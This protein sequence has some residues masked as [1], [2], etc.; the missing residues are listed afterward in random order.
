[1]GLNRAQRSG[2]MAGFCGLAGI[3]A[4]CAVASGFGVR[5]NLT[6]SLPMGLYIERAQGTLVE[7]CPPGSA[8]ELSAIRGYRGVGVCPDRHAPLLKPVVARQGDHVAIDAQGIRVNGA[9]LPNTQAYALDHRRRPLT[10]YPAGDYTVAPNTLWV[11][12]TWND[13][14][15]DSRYFGPIKV[16]SVRLTLAPLWVV[17]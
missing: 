17:E 10:S 5:V 6:P 13:G 16:E 2:A 14:S 7:F 12:S 15:F 9:P 8:A 1:M 11:A 3:G 4:L